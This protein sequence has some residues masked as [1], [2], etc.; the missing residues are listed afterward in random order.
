MGVGSNRPFKEGDQIEI[1]VNIYYYN[2]E[3][4]VKPPLGPHKFKFTLEN[5]LYFE[6]GDILK[7][8]TSRG[9]SRYTGLRFEGGFYYIEI[10]WLLNH[11][12]TYKRL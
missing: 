8:A 12:E 5:S 6:P 11:P 10:D 1:L 9:V 4:S 3:Y 7:A 2:K